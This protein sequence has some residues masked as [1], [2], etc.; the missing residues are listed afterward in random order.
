MLAVHGVWARRGALCLWAEAPARLPLTGSDAE[1]VREALAGPLPRL[2]HALVARARGTVELQLPSERG[3]ALQRLPAVVLGPDR[4]LPVLLELHRQAG[5]GTALPWPLEVGEDLRWLA[6]LAAAADAR[7]R[8]GLLVPGL[9]QAD[10]E[11]WGRWHP[12]VDRAWRRWCSAAAAAAPPAARAEDDGRIGRPAEELVTAVV[13]DL[14]AAVGAQLAAALPEPLASSGQ[15]A[16][17]GVADAGSAW[18]ASLRTGEPVGPDAPARALVELAARAERWRASATTQ[19]AELLLRVAEPADEDE[20]WTLQ[21]RLRSLDDP[22]A[23]ATPGE[24]RRGVSGEWGQDW[25]GDLDPWAFA[26]AEL[27]R[28]AAVHPA[29]LELGASPDADAELDAQQVVDL[30]TDGVP[31]L[32]GAGFA[33]A[34]PGRWLRPQVG[35]S[36][37]ARRPGEGPAPQGTSDVPAAVGAPGSLART[38]LV[39]VD[40]KVVLGDVELD[41]AELAVLAAQRAPL[42]QLRGQWVQVD[43]DA[44]ERSLRFLRRSVHQESSLTSLTGVL[45]QLASGSLPA[46]LVSLDGDGPLGALLS[47]EQRTFAPVPAPAGLQAQLRPYQERGLAWMAFLDAHGL[48]GVLADDMGLGKTVQLLALLLSE[49]ERAAPGVAPGPTLLVCPMSVVGNWERE[50]ARFAPDLRVH[51]HHGPDRLRG[52]ELLAA[53]GRSDLVL[54]TYPLVARDADDLAAVA[55]RRVALDEAQHVKNLGTRAA[56]AVRQVAGA[57]H[58]PQGTQRI[59]L[60]GTPVEN[61]LAELHAVVDFTNPGVLG[62]ATRFRERF[63]VPVERH[64]DERATQLLTTL[65]RPFV[66][67][68][69][70]TDPGVAPDL[71]AKLELVVRA[72]LTTEQAALYKAVVDEMLARIKEAEEHRDKQQRRG[73]VL[74]TLTRLKQV[75]NHP[76]QLLADGSPFLRRGQHRSG[77]LALVDDVLDTVVADGEKALLFT[78]YRELGALLVPHLQQRYGV[79]VPYLHGGVSKKARDAMVVGFSEGS[80]S[81]LMLLSLRAGGTGLNLVAANHVVHVD[82]WWNPAVEAQATDRAFRIGQTRQVQVRKLVCVGTVEERVDELMTRKADLASSVVRST[83]A[84]GGSGES[85]LTELSTDELHDLVR[86]GAEAVGD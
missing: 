64:G 65:T 25:D 11:W 84:D 34:L 62:S 43:A 47:G 39:E 53:A 49:R 70:K 44:I 76:A 23:V 73:L 2:A 78:Q 27:G 36:V 60:T 51:T 52:E 26:V 86:L 72:N 48:G 38:D 24:V 8:A 67:R 56:R 20:P 33:V 1:A 37:R 28:A 5:E 66:L 7:A 79:E 32:V 19:P 14:T 58:P 50:A 15:S 85:W 63:S 12:L 59:A 69:T 10:G 55:W 81:P 30:V 13:A 57:P 22:S 3:L 54:S 74:A 61:R 9:E 35:L 80:A 17:G 42:V 21:V 46:P 18:L 29:L 83:D 45:G 71:P 77:K 68:R 16:P 4:A 40:W 31:A 82:R 6:G 75:C 41:E